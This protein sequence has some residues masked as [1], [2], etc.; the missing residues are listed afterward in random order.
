MM[1]RSERIGAPGEALPLRWACV[2]LALLSALPGL[3]LLEIIWKRSE[4]LGHGYLIPVV[5]A[6]LVFLR[7]EEVLAAL[8]DG[9]VPATGPLWV[10]L[11]ALVETG[12]VAAE[13]VTLAGAGVAGL[14]AA[15]AY[16]LGGLR[17]LRALALPIGFL[18]LMVPPPRFFE[19]RVLLALTNLVAAWASA[20]MELLG[21]SVARLGNRILVPGHELFV[22]D[23]CS[24]LTSVITLLPLGVVVAYFLS[25]G[26][27]RR[28]AIVAA[29]VPL[30][31]IFNVARVMVTIA[32]V[33]DYGERFAQGVLH[34]SLGLAT[35]LFG[36]V[37]LLGLARLLRA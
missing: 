27:W 20:G 8:R 14:F 6:S 5:C 34:E 31:V 37:A 21:F 29:I 16:A 11:A 17:L 12:A 24:G 25:H 33:D 18:L 1:N 19:D 23:A 26:V 28:V 36:T 4:Y 7:R 15:T 9:P 13:I 30:A 10:L 22:E 2:S 35:F 32:L 3:L